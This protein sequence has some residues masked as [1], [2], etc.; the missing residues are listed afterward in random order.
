MGV[1][2][3][4]YSCPHINNIQ[5]NKF[6]G[7]N[8][9][10][11]ACFRAMKQEVHIHYVSRF[12]PPIVR[13]HGCLVSSHASYARGFRVQFLNREPTTILYCKTARPSLSQSSSFTLHKLGD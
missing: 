11:Q 4:L 7:Y 9:V 8:P 2:L 13:H 1:S 3:L 6:H 5:R 10:V 12:A